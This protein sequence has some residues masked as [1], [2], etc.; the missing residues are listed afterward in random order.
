VPDD[1][2]GVIDAARHFGWR[3]DTVRKWRH[4]G[5]LPAPDVVVSGSPAWRAITLEAW[6]I[7]TGREY[8]RETE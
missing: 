6:A 7:R 5:L 8:Q 3:V 1:L 4:R 2:L